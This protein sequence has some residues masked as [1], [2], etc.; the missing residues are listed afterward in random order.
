MTSSRARIVGGN[1]AGRADMITTLLKDFDGTIVDTE[2]ADAIAWCEEFARAG[3][4][5]SDREY[6]AW[7]PG[8]HDSAGPGRGRVGRLHGAA[9][10]VQAGQVT[11]EGRRGKPSRPRTRLLQTQWLRKVHLITWSA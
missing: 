10:L 9:Q 3:V 2:W 8:G 5:T 1:R 6:A 7:W 11:V 4:P